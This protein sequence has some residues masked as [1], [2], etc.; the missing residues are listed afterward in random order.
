MNKWI[1]V[2]EYQKHLFLGKPP[3]KN[4]IRK[5]CEK[6]LLPSKKIGGTWL[7]NACVLSDS[8]GSMLADKIL[9]DRL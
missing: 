5:W 4:T 7:I 6:G 1:T 9:N 3:S 8:T 2:N